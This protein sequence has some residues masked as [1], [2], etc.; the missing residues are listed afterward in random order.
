MRNLSLLVTHYL[1][2]SFKPR[3]EEPQILRLVDHLQAACGLARIVHSFDRFG[4]HIHMRLGVNAAR[5][6]EADEFHLR[7]MP[8]GF[9]VPNPGAE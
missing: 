9:P 7:V 5:D 8:P 4:N 2:K 6:G 3:L 1:L